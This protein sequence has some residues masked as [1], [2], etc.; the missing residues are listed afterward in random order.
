MSFSTVHEFQDH[1][2]QVHV[3]GNYNCTVDKCNKTFAK[4][5]LLDRHVQGSHNGQFK[6]A[7]QDCNYFTP[8]VSNYQRHMVSARCLGRQNVAEK[9]KEHQAVLAQEQMAHAA[10]V[11]QYSEREY[12]AAAA[13]LE[14]HDRCLIDCRASCG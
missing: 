14:L 10:V 12:E 8:Y 7:C 4:K 11:G 6:F 13:L 5:A 2:N 1:K 9:N 3:N